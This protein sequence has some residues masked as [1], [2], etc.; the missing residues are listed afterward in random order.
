MSKMYQYFLLL[1]HWLL[2][3]NVNPVVSMRYCC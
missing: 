3:L 1:S 2:S